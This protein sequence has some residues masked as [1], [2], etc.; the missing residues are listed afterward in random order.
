MYFV[1]PDHVQAKTNTIYYESIIINRTLT[2]QQQKNNSNINNSIDFKLI[3]TT[4]KDKNY[5]IRNER[6]ENYI[7]EHK[8][9]EELCQ[10]NGSLVRDERR[11]VKNIFLFNLYFI[12]YI[13]NV[14]QNYFVVIVI[15]IIHIL[16]YNQLKKNNY[17][18]NQI[19]IFFMILLVTK[20]LKKSNQLLLQKYV[21]SR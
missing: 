7:G 1:V 10:Q 3:P 13:Q 12:S 16:F 8:L 17:Q 5:I 4:K 21:L 11:T 14:N 6:S 20:I 15:I 9:Y 2:E 18:L 19:F